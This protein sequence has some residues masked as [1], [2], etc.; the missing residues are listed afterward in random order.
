M[1]HDR[2]GPGTSKPSLSAQFF[3][4]L[5]ARA[6]VAFSP[7]ALLP[8]AAARG[9]GAEA[10]DPAV[11]SALH[12]AIEALLQP[13]TPAE[14]QQAHAQQLITTL[15][16]ETAHP[17]DS[18][19]TQSTGPLVAS[20]AV[21]CMRLLRDKYAYATR[22][23]ACELLAATLRFADA[24]MARASDA[25][26]TQPASAASWDTSMPTLTLSALDR[27]LLFK[28]VVALHDGTRSP[29]LATLARQIRALQALTRDGRD[30]VA[31][32]QIVGVLARWLLPAWAR[33]Q[34][35]RRARSAGNAVDEAQLADGEQCTQQ[36]LHLL[37]GVLKFNFARI[38]PRQLHDALFAVSGMVL[39]SFVQSEAEPKVA[40]EEHVHHAPPVA[41]EDS[42]SLFGLEGLGTY[43]AT[44]ALPAQPTSPA[45]APAADAG[46]PELT[47]EDVAALAGVVDTTICYGLIPPRCIAS[48][49]SM[50]CA[51]LGA[52][53]LRAPTDEVEKA[54][55]S[56]PL[57]AQPRLA[58][59][60]SNLLRSHCASATLRIV[61]RLLWPRSA[62][63]ERVAEAVS[64]SVLL[65]ALRFLHA[66][67]LRAAE[68]QE[69]LAARAPAARSAP[70]REKPVLPALSFAAIALA[71]EGA[72]EKHIDELDLATVL[73]VHDFLPE[74]TTEQ[75][76]RLDPAAPLRPQSAAFPLHQLFHATPAD[77]DWDM[78]AA[79]TPLAQRHMGVWRTRGAGEP[80]RAQVLSTRVVYLL[81]E[82]LSGVLPERE[83]RSGER[84]DAEA[85]A[86][87]SSSAPAPRRSLVTVPQ[88]TPLLLVLAPLLP[89]RVLVEMVQE[90]RR[91]H[92][93]MPSSPQ[94][95]DSTLTLIHAFYFREKQHAAA[96][97]APLARL[98]IAQLIADAYDVVQDM[99]A[100]RDELA[101]RVLLPILET[102]V[103]DDTNAE[104]EEILRPA[105]RG[106]ALAA[107]LAAQ[108][109]VLGRFR[110]VLA[111]CVRGALATPE[112]ERGAL[113]EQAHAQHSRQTSLGPSNV[114]EMRRREMLAKRAVRA[115]TDGAYVFE[116][117]AF[118]LPRTIV[119]TTGGAALAEYGTLQE[120]ARRSC[121][122]LFRDLLEFLQASATRTA[123]SSVR[124]VVLQWFMRLRADR[125]HRIFFARNLD[126]EAATA[127]QLLRRT[128]GEAP[129]ADDEREMAARERGARRAR[130]ASLD[131]TRR[132]AREPSLDRRRTGREASLERTER[133]PSVSRSAGA[134]APAER[135]WTVPESVPFVL[136][137]AVEQPSEVLCIFPSGESGAA[138][139][140][141][142]AAGDAPPARTDVLPISEYLGVV[143]SMLQSESDWELVSYVIT[144]LPAQLSNKH[145]FC[146]P[147]CQRQIIALHT[148][149]CHAVLQQRLLAGVALPEE[150]RRTDMY[151]VAYGTLVVL[152]SYR[153]V[154]S[155]TQQDELVEAFIA[156][157]NKSQNT[158]Q[159]CM[160]ALVVA[161]HELQK[162]VT[163]HVSGMLVKLSTIMSSIAMSVHIMEL[164]AEIGSIPAAYANFTETD[165][166]RV[167]GIALQYIQYHQSDAAAAREDIRSSPGK[168]SL[169]QYVM[170]LAYFNIVLWFMTLRMGDRAKHVPHITRGLML[171]NEGREKLADQTVVCLDFLARFTYSNAEPKPSRSMIRF[172]VSGDM[173]GDAPR[174]AP[175]ADPAARPQTWLLGKGLLTITSLQHA[176]WFELSVRRPSGTTTLIAKLENLTSHSLM[177]DELK[178][179]MMPAILA[180]ARETSF[181][182]MDPYTAPGASLAA[183]GRRLGVNKGANGTE[184]AA[185]EGAADGGEADA[186]PATSGSSPATPSKSTDT[187]EARSGSTA[188]TA[189][190]SAGPNGSTSGPVPNPAPNAG[191]APSSSSRRSV[192]EAVLNPAYIA[193]QLS[194]FPD[195]VVDEAPILLPP[196]ASTDRMLRTIDLTPVYDFYKIGV[197]YVA[198]GQ[199]TEAE[200]LSNTYGSEAYMRFLS[201]LGDLIALRGQE[202]VYTGGLDRQSDEH[203]KYAYVWKDDCVQLVFHT[204]TLMPN[205]AHDSTCGAKKALI[206][207]DY[208][209][210][211]FN[212]SNEP[213]RFGTIA[214]QFN[215][216][217]IVISPHSKSRNTIDECVLDETLFFRVELQKRAGLPD[218]SPIGDGQLV[219]LAALPRF[220]RNLAMH[221]DLM[222]QIYLDTG[223]SM[224]PYRSN[225]VTRLQH[226][227]R[228][229]AQLQ[230]RLS[231]AQ[232]SEQDPMDARDFTQAFEG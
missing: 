151:A 206:G 86:E 109:E 183:L 218:F 154:F 192:R 54:L 53:A 136:G 91:L 200:I 60:I 78:L 199:K 133:T 162:S 157:L 67:L 169:S 111:A 216:V 110:S 5:R 6:N 89:D 191:G 148:H 194:P 212:D 18:L 146:G 25:A 144:H 24:C 22:V 55:G 158:A 52:P 227:E 124:L 83:E 195:M 41:L 101:V 15:R 198:Y 231:E 207:N 217:N 33:V 31:F 141:P 66:A 186:A 229:R 143:L 49:T 142:A 177:N 32:P 196:D 115:I 80:T 39:H 72:A 96:A 69:E 190:S 75:D 19:D 168:F 156:G 208:V 10:G 9:G 65:G 179:Y 87:P 145:C 1:D 137:R 203:G 73:L 8:T 126:R 131:R 88:L 138:G 173:P 204:A 219:S 64:P 46:A 36:L 139:P 100:L 28:Q 165:Y 153:Q 230:A 13:S 16:R 57:D 98:E 171:A 11:L 34:T 113:R 182:A 129:G 170:M 215:F 116:T 202:D 42:F 56:A 166:K 164:I 14:E 102:T 178:A 228:F 130:D 201:G 147:A 105:I 220:V 107:A 77:E 221:C 209:H 134:A 150:I 103:P 58:A 94:W 74:R 223:E 193:L 184:L 71:L 99:P 232:P 119:L 40:S 181:G 174:R 84:S 159:P 188:D 63:E 50:F 38:E 93:Y 20:L 117:L 81:V 175:P 76:A 112:Q 90:H 29:E 149:L 122:A 140:A 205:R 82:L 167:F 37:T 187:D 48:I 197:V 44:P 176:G 152:I 125:H 180:R 95:I 2:K 43:L 17:S 185:P 161:C 128:A 59:A 210:I 225:W 108:P 222:S 160:R 61:Y 4:T 92:A 226:V 114:S 45:E 26:A 163:R 79:L 172:L 7:D 21:L 189:P 224:V 35:L 3:R 70:R 85:G 97:P 30:V 214:S 123:P 23:L 127:A 211:V 104:I 51:L 106:S 213:Y 68:E 120:R 47:A 12:G 62:A 118:D 27:S 121:V 155:R 135:L 132:S